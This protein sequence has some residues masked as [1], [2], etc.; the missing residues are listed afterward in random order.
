MLKFGATATVCGL[1][2]LKQYDTLNDRNASA[3][4]VLWAVEI[5]KRMIAKQSIVKGSIPANI[6]NLFIYFR[7]GPTR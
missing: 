2:F 5:G 4:F 7:T 6:R 1:D 3:N